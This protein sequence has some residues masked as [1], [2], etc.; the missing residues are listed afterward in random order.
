MLVMFLVVIM[1]SGCSMSMGKKGLT[2]CLGSL[3]KYYEMFMRHVLNKNNNTNNNFAKSK[4]WILAKICK[5]AR[6]SK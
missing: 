2:Y 5:S 3:D 4:S 1:D 6:T